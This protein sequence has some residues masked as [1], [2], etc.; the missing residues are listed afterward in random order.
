MERNYAAFIDGGYLDCVLRREFAAPRID[1]AKIAKWMTAGEEP[2]RIYYYHC[3]PYLSTPATEEE[4]LR[5][6][7]KS[8]FFRRLEALPNF[9]V[10]LGRLERRNQDLTG[11]QTFIQKR[12][13]M[14]LGLDLVNLAVK[15]RITQAA[16]FT[17]DSDFLPAIEMAKAEGVVITLCHGQ[18]PRAHEELT[19]V[20]DRE[21]LLT[22]ETI[23][24]I[25]R[26]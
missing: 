11:H 7:R 12:V 14:M 19:L 16:I 21:S 23:K 6:N 18:A 3:L 15:R 1:Y 5:Y 2:I 22:E 4:Q 24:K 26:D 10:R 25:Q 13:D 17:G 8:G 9:T 20:C